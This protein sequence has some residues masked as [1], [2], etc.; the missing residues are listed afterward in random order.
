MQGVELEE[1]RHGGDVVERRGEAGAVERRADV[2][3]VVDGERECR[4]RDGV[5]RVAKEVRAADG[6]E[7]IL[8]ERQGGIHLERELD[9]GGWG[10]GW[11]GGLL[12]CLLGKLLL[13]RG[14]Q[15]RFRLGGLFRGLLGFLDFVVGGGGARCAA[16]VLVRATVL[17]HVVFAREGLVALGAEGVFLAGVLLRV[18]GSVTGAANPPRCRKA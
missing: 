5:E 13:D 10:R 2:V 3:H 14:F 7:V 15:L 11:R 16:A 8:V 4:H 9:L 1:R 6:E 17:L 18:T 12:L